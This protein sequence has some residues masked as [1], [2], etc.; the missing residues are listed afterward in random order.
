MTRMDFKTLP[1][2]EKLKLEARIGKLEIA[3]NES[4]KLL[5]AWAVECGADGEIGLAIEPITLKQLE[6]RVSKNQRLLKDSFLPT[7]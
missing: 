6:G 5:N 4:T 3:L 2:T 1:S 7:T